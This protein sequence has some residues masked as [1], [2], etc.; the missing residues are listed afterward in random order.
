MGEEKSF[1]FPLGVGRG[2]RPPALRAVLLAEPRTGVLDLDRRGVG[3]LN[4]DRVRVVVGMLLLGG[5]PRSLFRIRGEGVVREIF[6][7]EDSVASSTPV[8][9][10]VAVE[11]LD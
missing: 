9:V 5:G 10:G 2:N 1:S 4:L 8:A 11:V 6:F 7:E 3:S